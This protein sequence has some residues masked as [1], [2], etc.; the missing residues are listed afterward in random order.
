MA[1]TLRFK[2]G[3]VSGIPTAALG[4][5]LF[6]TDTF[7]LY[8]GNGTGNTRF[9]KY[10]ASGTT[11]QLLRGDGSLLTMPIVLTSPANG[12][13]LK[14]N[15]TNWVNS[16]DAGV[17]GSGVTNYVSKWT[18]T[19]AI[20]N[21]QIFDNG[22]NVGIGT[23]APAAPLSIKFPV[24]GNKH[25]EFVSAGGVNYIESLDRTSGNAPLIF[26]VAQASAY[27]GF[28]V[29]STTE[30]MRLHGTGNLVLGGTVSSDNGLRFQV[31]GDG[32]FSGSVGIGTTAITDVN[33]Y[34]RKTLSGSVFPAGVYIDSTVTSTSTTGAAYYTASVSTENATFT[35][36]NLYHFR[37]VQSTFGASS[38]VTNQYGFFVDSS[39]TG[40]TNDF[41]FY[42]N[43]A[44]G[45]GRWNL[46][47]NGTAANYLAGNTGIRNTAPARGLEV[48][49]DGTNWIS[50]TFTGSGG[51]EKVVIG[52]LSALAT[53]GAHNSAL[54]GWTN[55]QVSGAQL[56]FSISGSERMRL[57]SSGNLG[58]GVTPSSRL[59]VDAAAGSAHIRVSEA[60]T[61]R[62]FVGGANG[63]ATGLNGYFMVRG[64][65]GLVL[66]GNGNSSDLVIRPTTANVLIGTSTDSGFRLDVNGTM[67]V[68]GETSIITGG[69]AILNIDGLSTSTSGI[70]IKG[71]GTERGRISFSNSN[72]M[73]F[74]IGSSVTQYLEIDATTRAATFSSSVSAATEFRL[75]NNT[76][77]R[78]AIIDTNGAIAGGYNFKL[79]SNVPQHD[80]TGAISGYYYH[81]NGYIGWYTGTSQAANTNATERMRLDASGNL[82]LGVTPSAWSGRAIQIGA[83]ASIA[84]VTDDLML[85]NNAFYDGT[86]WKYI[87]STLASNYYQSAGVHVWR[88]APSGTAGNNITW[89]E[90]M[91]VFANGNL[92]VGTS[93]TDAGFKLDVSGTMRVSGASTLSGGV[94]LG[95][96]GGVAVTFPGGQ[97]FR[98]NGGIFIDYG[99]GGTGDLVFRRGAG[100]TNTLTL[101]VSDGAATFSSTAQAA[102]FITSGGTGYAVINSAATTVTAL[103]P[104]GGGTSIM[105]TNSNGLHIAVGTEAAGDLILASNNTERIRLSSNGF[106]SQ[107]NATNPS[108]SITDSYIQYSADVTAGNAAP[109]FRTENGAVI[110]L[111]QETTGVG[112]AIFS[113]GG[114]NSVLD[115]STFDGYTLRQ[116]VKA[117]RNQGILQ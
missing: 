91:R 40:A 18:S 27:V 107:L 63:I 114:G 41:G 36:P 10:I 53:I 17:T 9:Q 54:S 61:T 44:T 11:S 33:L 35:L 5:P 75:N 56:I 95:H 69:N 66:S 29:G 83:R 46:Y 87:Q 80:S 20:G 15:G 100:V 32:F 38:T 98:S 25:I 92:L 12:E 96:T 82:G 14:Y 70:I 105:S 104:T 6:T 116:I 102:G 42:G 48:G 3:L 47:M 51:T 71:S 59:H 64:E 45:T 97:A 112:N 31:T 89:T 90:Q 24:S 52:N 94:T 50:G 62:G 22:T 28:T 1:N 99:N 93:G 43:I 79:T 23:T 8:I 110:K 77:S 73:R 37:A 68:S 7:D 113:Q 57:D 19:G 76:F 67:R 30:R 34:I 60:G 103:R 74:F 106:F 13:V 65:A 117:L 115:D 16:S 58:L 109:H 49:S 78:A 86:N 39:L 4:E 21:S 2:R 26:Y 72:N 84:S 55:L 108:A 85:T 81:N 111:Y 101:A 88:T